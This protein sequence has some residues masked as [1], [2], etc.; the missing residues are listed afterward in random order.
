MRVLGP[1]P[2]GDPAELAAVV[3]EC[4]PHLEDGLTLLDRAANAGEITV[5]VAAVDARGRLVLIVCDIVG[6]P[7]T[8]LRAVESVAWWREHAG[9][10]ARVIPGAGIDGAAEPRA[11]VVASRFTDRALRLIRALGPVAPAAVECR[12]FEDAGH[13]AAVSLD[14]VDAVPVRA[15]SPPAT[16]GDAD[17]RRAGVLI[18]RLERLR[19][20]EGFR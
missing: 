13:D 20:S 7:E 16:S 5:D 1:R 10:A 15:P 3:A 8:V 6:G 12:V 19:F 14:R 9:L 17:A 18:E 11:F 4:L 2:V